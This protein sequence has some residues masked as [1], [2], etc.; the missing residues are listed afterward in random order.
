[1]TP[2]NG[3]PR[4]S[5][6]GGDRPPRDCLFEGLPK[7]GE[8]LAAYYETCDDLLKRFYLIRN[9]T[10]WFDPSFTAASS[11]RRSSTR[12]RRKGARPR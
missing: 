1:M 9:E 6:Y 12:A 2:L 11:A 4:T 7:K 10:R 3:N 5:R 8:T